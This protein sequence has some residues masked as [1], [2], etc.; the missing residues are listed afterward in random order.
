MLSGLHSVLASAACTMQ[1][2]NAP[3]PTA[4]KTTAAM[5]CNSNSVGGTIL[6]ELFVCYAQ[7]S[8]IHLDFYILTDILKKIC[9][10]GTKIQSE[11]LTQNKV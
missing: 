2:L 8:Y 9:F 11:K 3:L 1:H 7:C 10:A 5:N 4:N 6:S